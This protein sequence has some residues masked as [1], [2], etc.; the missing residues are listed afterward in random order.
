VSELIIKRSCGRGGRAGERRGLRDMSVSRRLR[1]AELAAESNP[2]AQSMR[3]PAASRALLPP[4]AAKTQAQMD[5]F[6]TFKLKAK[7]KEGAH[8]AESDV[9]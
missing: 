6:V 7:E 9:R 8:E 3:R 4:P 2:D 1:E 5:S